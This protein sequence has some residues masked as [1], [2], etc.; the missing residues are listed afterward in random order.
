[1]KHLLLILLLS[2]PCNAETH[3]FILSGQSNMSNLNPAASFTPTISQVSGRA[4]VVHSASPGQPISHWLEG[5]GLDDMMAAVVKANVDPDT[6]TVCWMQG[7]SDANSRLAKEYEGKL[8]LLFERITDTLDFP[9][10]MFVVG[11]LCRER[12]EAWNVIRE[13]Q[14]AAGDEYGSWIDTDD[15]PLTADYTH[16]TVA[17]YEEL[18]VRLAKA[19]ALLSTGEAVEPVVVDGVQ[20]DHSPKVEENGCFI[21]A[22]GFRQNRQ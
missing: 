6:I 8:K 11:R 20:E 9:G 5:P 4:V 7:E 19:A 15:L 14:V 1:M 10:M 2:V 21:S 18:G 13:I 12:G 22:I 16:H 17:G 3:L